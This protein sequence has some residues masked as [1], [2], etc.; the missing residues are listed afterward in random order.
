MP[1]SCV[2]L[3]RRID[4][5]LSNYEKQARNFGKEVH[6]IEL[7][8]Y[9]FCALVDEV[10]LSPGAPLRDEWAQM[11][12]QLRLFGDDF[13]GEHFFDRLEEARNDP[14]RYVEVLEVFY[15]CMLLGFQGKYLLEGSEKLD[16]L[17]RRVGQEIQRVRGEAAEFS[18]NWKLPHRFQSFVRHELPLWAYF[19]LLATML[20]IVFGV[21]LAL[22]DRQV[23]GIL[24]G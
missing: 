13:A 15:T 21:F 23:V 5:F 18:P 19:A 1:K 10:M 20:A 3:N 7:A 17:V 8:K 6:Q 14:A 12:L 16:Y 22:L 24:G 9:A 11:P 4:L 2:Q